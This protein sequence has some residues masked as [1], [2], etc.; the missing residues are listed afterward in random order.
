MNKIIFS[1]LLLLILNGCGSGVSKATYKTAAENKLILS[2]SNQGFDYCADN[3][4]Y[5]Y[6]A[7][8]VKGDE[9]IWYG[10]RPTGEAYIGCFAAR[11]GKYT[12]AVQKYGRTE[13]ITGDWIS[14]TDLKGDLNKTRLAIEVD[15][16]VK[17]LDLDFMCIELMKLSQGPDEWP[18]FFPD[19]LS[20]AMFDEI[21]SRTNSINIDATCQ[22]I[23][24]DDFRARM[25]ESN[26]LAFTKQVDASQ[27]KCMQMGFSLETPDMSKCI[28]ELIA[29]DMSNIIKSKSIPN[30][31]VVDGSSSDS[32]IADELKK[33]N[34]RENQKYYEKM[35]R[36]GYDMM[37]CYTWPNC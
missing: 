21:A 12:P 1:L 18:E 16:K 30:T 25:D 27:Q 37:T 33:M 6:G 19:Y 29:A 8:D 5:F 36:T 24:Y 11:F 9:S 26:F 32:A 17:K 4:G 35:M 2:E 14:S 28:L 10:L 20:R 7:L 13:L 31:V 3:G 23:A 34:R 22:P 15:D